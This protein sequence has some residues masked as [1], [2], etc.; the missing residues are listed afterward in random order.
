[1]KRLRT[2]AHTLIRELRRAL[3]SFALFERYEKDFLFYER[4]LN[5]QPKDSNK[6]YAL[7]EPDVYC[8]GKGK[9]HKLY[10]YGNKVSIAAKSNV[11]VGVISHL[12]NLHDSKTLPEVLAH[13]QNSRGKVVKIG[14]CDRGYRGR[15][16]LAV[17]TSFCRLLR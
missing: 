15:K 8:I 14:V 3:P 17:R 2:M 6:I 11:I 16:Q 5:Q 7:H 4:V 1:L 12:Q 13:C 9:D 10:E